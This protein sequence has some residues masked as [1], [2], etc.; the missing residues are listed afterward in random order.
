MDLCITHK[1]F[2]WAEPRAHYYDEYMKGKDGEKWTDSLP[3]D[4][5]S[6]LFGFIVHWDFHFQGDPERFQKSTR[7]SRQSLRT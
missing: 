7:K 1:A 5:V 4:E 6:K 3:M 2:Y